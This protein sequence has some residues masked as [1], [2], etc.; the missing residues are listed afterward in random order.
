MYTR[1]RPSVHNSWSYAPW[2]VFKQIKYILLNNFYVCGPTSMKLKLIPY[3]GALKKLYMYGQW[4]DVS[5]SQKSGPRAHNSL[6]KF[7]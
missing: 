5:C 6:I 7:P 3:L 1:I 4:I 2:Y